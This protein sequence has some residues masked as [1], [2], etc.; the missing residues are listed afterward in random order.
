MPVLAL[1]IGGTKIA[2]ALVSDDGEVVRSARAPTAG[3]PWPVCLALLQEVRG[4]EAV[5]GIGAGSSGPMQWPSGRLSP[6]NV[7]G[8]RDFPLR[9]A[10]RD[11]F[12]GLPVR[13][14]NDAACVA[15]GEHWRGAGRGVDDLVGMVVSTGVGGG[16]VL[17]GRLVDGAGGNAGHIGHVVVEPD[18]PDCV[19]GGRGCLE[20][21]ARGPAVVAA[22]REQGCPAR[23]GVELAELARSGDEIAVRAISRAGHAVGVGVASAAAL[24]DVR[25]VII[26]GGFASVGELFWEPLQAAFARHA[27]L[28]FLAR[29]RVVP[30]ELGGAAGLVGAAALVLAGDRYW[31]AD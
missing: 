3:D 2:A 1:D 27:R 12:P 10:L 17:G 18:G 28:D 14:H 4:T 6:L 30:A 16:L 24:L 20:A 29:T 25:R 13:V 19:C 26:G 9:D 7:P 15:V 31:S 8:W 23:D 22:A 21:V 11:A 5:D